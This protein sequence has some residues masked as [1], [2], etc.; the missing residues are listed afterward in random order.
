MPTILQ[1]PGRCLTKTFATSKGRVVKRAYDSATWFHAQTRDVA[2]VDELADLLR[3]LERHPD[4][5]IIR[6][7]PGRY[8]PHGGGLVQRRVYAAVELVDDRRRL[9]KPARRGGAALWQEQEIAAGRL[10]P[11][12]VLP[13]FVEQLTDWLLFDFDKINAPAGIDWRTD[14]AWT[15]AY[16]RLRLPAEF[17]AARCAFFA[18]SSAADLTKPDLGGDEI[19]M[20]L[21]FLLDRGVT[22]AEAKR[23]LAGVEGLDES[24]LRP[25]QPIYT[26]R[27][28]FLDGLVDPLP[29]RLGVLNGDHELVA[30]PEIQV[31]QRLKRAEFIS[32]GPVRSA[33]G[34]GLVRPHP[35]LDAA[36]DRLERDAGAAGAVRSGLMRAIN[37]YVRDAGRG[38]VDIDALA[39]FLA[40]V[41][42]QYRTAAEVAGY[43][44][45]AMI[46][47]ALER[48][49]D[50]P[51]PR[52]H[53]PDQGLPADQAAAL[54]KAEMAFAVAGAI[55]WRA[56]AAEGELPPVVGIK[57]GAGIGKTGAALEQIA[58]IPGI[59]QM[60]IELYVPDHKLALE[61]A[62]R[63]RIAA[64][65][66]RVLVIR[67]R[68]AAD[69]DDTPMC[70]KAE[71]AEAIG[72]SGLNVMGHLCRLKAQDGGEPQHCEFASACRYLAQFR[73]DRPAIRIF[74]HA[75]MFIH[76]NKALPEPDLIVI[77]ESFWSGAVR[78]QTLAL[79]RVAEA[80]RW[81]VRPK[82][83]KRAKFASE[84][85]R[86]AEA[87]G[88]V[89]ARKEAADRRQ[90]AE[91]FAHR[92]RRAFEEDRDP[93]EVVTA[94]ECKLVAAIEWGSRSG[95]GIEPGMAYAD[96]R[97]IWAD[98]RKDECAKSGRF[99]DLLADEHR[100]PAR[101]LQRVVLKR[102]QPTRDG[103]RRHLLDLHSRKD[104]HLAQ[105]PVILLDA[106]HD[107]IIAGKFFPTVH[108]VDIPV[109][110]QAEIIQVVDKTCAMTFLM[111]KDEKDRAR[112]ANR[113]AE[114]ERFAGRVLGQGGL[115]VGYKDALE[116]IKL[117]AQVDAVHLGNLRG[118][119][120]YK[121][122]DVAVIAG[123]LEPATGSM[124][125]QAR[126]MFGDEPEPILTVAAG[127]HG[128]TRYPTEPRRYRMAGG[129]AG[130]AVDV[131]VHPDERVQ[132]LLQQG[133]ECELLQ[134]VARLRLIHR[135]RPAKVYIL[136]SIPLDLEVAALTTWHALVCDREAEAVAR[137]GGVWLCSAS[138][139]AK[140]APDLWATA[141][142]AEDDH[143]RKGVADPSRYTTRAPCYPFPSYPG[144]QH[145]ARHHAEATLVEYR[146]LGQRGSSHRAY[147]PG[148]FWCA[149]AA[150]AV[151][152]DV[153]GP[154]A[155][156]VL[157]GM[158]QREQPMLLRDRA[159]PV[160][161]AVP[162]AAHS[163]HH[164]VDIDEAWAF[165]GHDTV[166]WTLATGARVVL[167]V[168]LA[169]RYQLALRPPDR[170]A[171]FAGAS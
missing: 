43:G 122:H 142:A 33:D 91:V 126:A 139:R 46:E 149:D 38:H 24:T 127:E 40:E 87:F 128:G 23:W 53:Y 147:L 21:G 169:A 108:D 119:D 18:T 70:E 115:F 80:A 36:L 39:A 57:A 96:Q 98:W 153:T 92:V 137:W 4:C 61:L 90:D 166:R 28:R 165:A 155:T 123:R 160:P 162:I 68:G 9:Q 117:P 88:Q 65:H 63:A 83:T 148:N 54:L 72:K 41:G 71:L 129:G 121:H 11:V 116:M 47:W 99:W 143:R 3:R 156:A 106:D 34:L 56:T 66:V 100:F 138:E 42:E 14:L 30:V 62:E 44:I 64:P 118:R 35:Q 140:A 163:P 75:T 104:L 16:L 95:P 97:R 1:A 84:E 73:D 136:T 17:H 141:Q 144:W 26:G 130:Q 85:E 171:V 45:E 125:D 37:A 74:S 133:R 158:V 168:D 12:T 86:I 146:R 29:V 32:L 159:E 77:D 89:K 111:G 135:D 6:A 170:P 161:I 154:V 110:Q 7:A 145:I 15:A 114:L 2:T 13:A 132:R 81:R 49:P 67:G 131:A 52:P 164:V 22:F 112:G 101:P 107:P 8:F 55:G 109:R 25:A 134:A 59:E 69:T 93:R 76:R 105:A 94:E 5:C 152:E 27:P 10:W 167:P 48:A 82:K 58:A 20:R 102:D 151:L 79:D 124:E 120:S 150:R 50:D 78:N 157:V 51:P 19:R 31:E 60:N 103:D 113:L